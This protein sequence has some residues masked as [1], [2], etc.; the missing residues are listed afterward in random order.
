M[1]SAAFHSLATKKHLG[2]DLVL[3]FTEHC[4]LPQCPYCLLML[5]VHL[6][7]I[8]WVERPKSVQTTLMRMLLSLKIR[9]G[10]C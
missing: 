4:A 3:Y 9:I 7:F 8:L 1:V 10:T 6:P 2:L 5:C